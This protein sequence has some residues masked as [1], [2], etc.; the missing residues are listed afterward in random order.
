M[1]KD[2]R[3]SSPAL[4]RRERLLRLWFQAYAGDP[5]FA[6][7]LESFYQDHR[8]SFAELAR[9]G[10]LLSGAHHV[11]GAVALADTLDAS[12]RTRDSIA[13][14]G[15]FALEWQLH[16]VRESC[17]ALCSWL[18]LRQTAGK[19]RPPT[20]PADEIGDDWD[21]SW[22][23]AERKPSALSRDELR[24][25]LAAIFPTKTLD[26]IMLTW[27]G[28]T[29]R[30]PN[31]VAAADFGRLNEWLPVPDLLQDEDGDFVAEVDGVAVGTYAP[32]FEK[33]S[34][35]KARLR[36]MVGEERANHAIER[37]VI[38]L[39]REGYDLPD[40]ESAIT[41]HMGW[42]LQRV[43]YRRTTA[44]IAREQE[45]ERDAASVR[46]PTTLLAKRLQITIPPPPMRTR[47]E[48]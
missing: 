40:S 17:D 41:T 44:A 32:D 19:M 36:T 38:G 9:R 29:E 21:W 16:Q 6:A 34:E 12:Q 8:L 33:A 10:I 24:K 42:L 28:E 23:Y 35:A 22:R 48:H 13:A 5:D 27:K 31:V 20:F 2:R 46:V 39:I 1:S 30:R 14:I 4:P 37:I 3:Q 45:P 25:S 43:V 15:D 7:S 18:Q 11:V 26:R 47:I